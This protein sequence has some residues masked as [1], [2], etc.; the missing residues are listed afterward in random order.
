M[1]GAMCVVESG[2]PI[3]L[4]YAT[5]IMSG[6]TLVVLKTAPFKAKNEDWI[7]F[8]VATVLVLDTLAGFS[9][10]MDLHRDPQALDSNA[11]GVGLIIMNALCIVLQIA[12][13][14]IVEW[15]LYR[16]CTRNKCLC[17]KSKSGTHGSNP[18]VSGISVPIQEAAAK[19][20]HAEDEIRDQGVDSDLQAFEKARSSVVKG[21]APPISPQ[22]R[23]NMLGTQQM[24]HK[25][26]ALVE[27]SHERLKKQTTSQTAQLR[28]AQIL[29]RHTRGLRSTELFQQC[30]EEQLKTLI[31]NM[32]LKTFAAGEK[33]VT[34]DEPGDSFM[35]IVKGTAD[36][37]QE[38]H[39]K[40]ATLNTTENQRMIGEASLVHEGHKRTATV[41]ATGD[42]TQVL[43]LTR[44]VF[45]ALKGCA[46]FDEVGDKA[47]RASKSFVT[48]DSVRKIRKGTWHQD[49][50]LNSWDDVNEATTTDKKFSRM[51]MIPKPKMPTKPSSEPAETSFKSWDDGDEV[52]KAP[53]MSM[54]ARPISKLETTPTP[55]DIA[56]LNDAHQKHKEHKTLLNNHRRQLRRK[57]TLKTQQRRRAQIILRHTKGLRKTELFKEYSDKR[58]QSIIESME[59]RSFKH[60]ED[61]VTENQ[62][63]NAFMVIM[64]GSADVFK[65]GHEG[66]IKTL[67]VN[68]SLGEASLMAAYYL[69]SATVKAV[70]EVQ[71][72]VLTRE[73]F[74]ALKSAS[75]IEQKTEEGM[76]RVSMSLVAADE[77]RGAGSRPA[78]PPLKPL[79][80][81]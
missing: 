53:R 22:T 75:L 48:A 31:D 66:K 6:Y 16:K 39:G 42:F 14:V 45:K 2:S 51:S 47:R 81:S 76:R 43:V 5:F 64:K 15:K 65:E 41:I 55:P 40:I 21:K 3:Q 29:L 7:S 63:G 57:T 36:V 24:Q 25:A 30:T 69:R 13:A 11:I 32:E 73:S 80:F 8:I 28:Q 62:P 9:L 52:G 59:F 67:H 38:G 71:V 1:T 77:A 27:E 17:R 58:L 56:K 78:P 35:V 23:N 49:M 46:N 20:P 10:I 61:L 34:E 12:V 37:F 50:S 70:G 26:A 18:E 54:I 74:L 4:L 19:K 68:E 79:T 44:K 60:G 72:L 33:I